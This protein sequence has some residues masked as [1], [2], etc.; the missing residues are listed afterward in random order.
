MVLIQ[1]RYDDHGLADAFYRKSGQIG[2]EV[3][4]LTSDL[5]DIAQRWVQSEA[6]R[7]TG[8]LKAS[9]QKE[10]WGSRGLVWIAKGIAP[11]WIYVVEGTQP[12]VIRAKYKKA[13]KTPYGLFKS[14]NHPGTKANPFVDR[15][16]TKMQGDIDRRTSIFEKWLIEV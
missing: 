2:T 10:T 11:Y 1:F 13:L 6:P 9:I 14:V 3:N 4:K 16:A 5:T 8:K 15:A 12:H 7:K